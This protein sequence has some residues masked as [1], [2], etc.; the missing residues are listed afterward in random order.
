MSTVA[1]LRG[2]LG[3]VMLGFLPV[4]AAQHTERERKRPRLPAGE[5]TNSAGAYYGY[6]LDQLRRVPARAADAFYWA[7]RLEPGMPEPWYGLSAA[8]SL[9]EPP[10]RLGDYLGG[11]PYM[12]KDRQFLHIDSLRY[13]ALIRNPMLY[14]RLDALVLEEWVSRVT[15]G[16][17]SIQELS[18]DFGPAMAAWW[19]YGTGRFVESIR[20]YAIA[21]A[22]HPK[23]YGLRAD[24]AR[25][26]LPLMQF[27]SAIATYNELLA[28]QQQ[29]EE[30][31][32]VHVYNSKELVHFTIGRIRETEGNYS[33]AREA[34]G[35]ALTE[36]LAFHPAHLAMARLDLVTGDSAGAET[37]YDQTVQIDPTDAEAHYEYGILL[38][39]RQ[40]YEAAVEQFQLAVDNEPYFARPYF[41]LALLRETEG[42]D[43]VA[44]AAY[45]RF[46]QI[47]PANL[48]AQV[49]EARRHVAAARSH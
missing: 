17:I 15:R 39:G 46:I 47:A 13:K 16:E 6:G 19:A 25:A 29:A 14:L 9:A 41:P 48:N 7:T 33:A 42:K 12:A 26:F 37:E 2:T 40:R 22:Q 45:Q 36:N 5:D 4:L 34:Y 35:R 8:L 1:C 44:I 30:E 43:S 3:L 23:W 24:R 27:D 32:L 10:E 21:V 20:Q 38:V 49:E 31:R 28:L 18:S 11:V